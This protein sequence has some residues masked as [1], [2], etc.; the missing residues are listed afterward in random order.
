MN[1]VATHWWSIASLPPCLPMLGIAVGAMAPMDS[2]TRA[3]ADSG[4]PV[5]GGSRDRDARGAIHA[6][7]FDDGSVRR[8]AMHASDWFETGLAAL[9]A[10]RAHY[11][12]GES[13]LAAKRLGECGARTIIVC[14]IAIHLPHAAEHHWGLGFPV[15]P[16]TSDFATRGAAEA[17]SWAVLISKCI[18]LAQTD[19]AAR[20]WMGR[21]VEAIHGR[22][23]T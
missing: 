14:S 15:I 4:R 6:T 13:Q 2:G 19:A 23:R 21:A 1:L 18:A 22:L 5:D 10:G 11:S 12:S 8:F 16:L 9:V 17:W 7:E 3:P 20:D